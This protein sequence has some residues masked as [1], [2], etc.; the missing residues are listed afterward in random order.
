MISRTVPIA[1]Y[2]AR[3]R[4]IARPACQFVRFI[5]KLP[6]STNQESKLREIIESTNFGTEA[7]KKQQQDE[8][9][10]K[11]DQ[12][13]LQKK[14]DEEVRVRKEH[15]R[16]DADSIQSSVKPT[17][18]AQDSSLLQEINDTIQKEIGNL[19]SQM[20]KSRSKMAERLEM[21][22]DSAQDTILTATRTL[23]DVTG[24][25]AIEKLK[26]SI[27]VLEQELRESKEHVKT[28]KTA[29]SEAIQQRAT[30][31]RE[32]NE[33][34]TRKHNWT[35]DDLE[36]FTELYRND[37]A[38]EHL[39]S[40]SEAKLEEAESKVDAIQL[41]LT[42][43]IL[44][45][46]HEEQIWSDKI[47]RSSTWGT[48]ILMGINVMLFMVATF[49]VEPW[50][51]RKL[52]RAFEEKVKELLTNGHSEHSPDSTKLV[53]PEATN[54]V[55]TTV[56]KPKLEQENV[57]KVT[58]KIYTFSF[59]E[60]SWNS[61]KQLVLSNYYALTNAD[62]TKLQFNKFEFEMFTLG[63]TL[64]ACSLGS[65]LTLWLR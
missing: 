6:D 47:R 53:V 56:E 25:S 8:I 3:S 13:E 42:Q 2:I 58:E 57:A 7:L 38:N 43:S 54:E 17:E 4:L 10:K 64:L 14:I 16:S 11:Q 29:Y 32:I 26:K 33:L 59:I 46:Y 20:E 61:F 44:T 51:R 50:K 30:S 5:S 45:R 60:Y 48:W 12:I 55:V 21:F 36:R 40:E 35:P 22:L 65:L 31:Q 15:D 28:R 24:Y 39:E 34:L 23:N 41:K 49:F 18:N 27:E 19:P 62:I 52:V 63:L 1:R 37:H 9:R